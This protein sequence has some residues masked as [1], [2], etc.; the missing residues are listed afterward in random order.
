MQ[1]KDVSTLLAGQDNARTLS[2]HPLSALEPQLDLYRAMLCQP[3]GAIRANDDGIGNADVAAAAKMYEAVLREA[4]TRDSDLVVLPEYSV[5]WSVIRGI[6]AGDFRP[7][8]G[9]LWALGCESITPDDLDQFKTENTNRDYIR[10]I[11]EPWDR[12]QRSQK[13]F[14]DPLVYVFWARTTAGLSVLC[15]LVQF[16][17]VPCRDDD[18]LELRS[19]YLGK[20]IYCFCNPAGSIRLLGFICSD[21]FGFDDALIRQYLTDVLILHIQLNKT[22]GNPVYSAY[23]TRLYAEASHNNVEILC[24]NWAAG[25]TTEGDRSPW[26][27][28]G[29]SCW[30]V[31]PPGCR[32]NDDDVNRLHATGVYYSLLDTR[33]HGFFLNFSS[34]LVI[35]EKRRVVVAG[36]QILAPRL[37]PRV[38][39]RKAWDTQ[40]ESW[41]ESAANDGFALMLGGYGALLPALAEMCQ[42]DPLAVERAMELLEGP[43][44]TASEWFNVK[45]LLAFRV[46]DHESLR[47]VTANQE[48]DRERAGVKFRH[49]RIRK[50][51]AAVNVPGQQM[52][53]PAGASD[54]EGGFVFQ[55]VSAMPHCNIVP[56]GEGGRPATLIFL[57]DEPD[58]REITNVYNKLSKALRKQAIGDP[59]RATDRLC[60]VYRRNNKLEAHKPSDWASITEPSA[61]LE[62]DIARGSND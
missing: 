20:D 28:I 56:V 9:S 40:T 33:W 31:S 21:A 50:A 12:R 41:L 47:R 8:P 61:G 18:N 46:A 44:G 60:V 42:R 24:L 43:E 14:I 35:F 1:V 5:P 25:V 6:V 19:L 23:R 29:G 59:S 53:W 17:T 4:V 54:L 34:H 49:N 55:W 57:G 37:P 26:N 36:A 51:V 45:Q 32:V 30:Y 38:V 3:R 10:V 11:Y 27:L 22:P 16:K 39:I 48:D 13:R 58:S 15:F 7:S 52:R 62:D 2:I